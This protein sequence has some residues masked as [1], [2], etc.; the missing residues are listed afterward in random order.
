[1]E[2]GTLRIVQGHVLRLLSDGDA[3]GVACRGYGEV[4]RVGEFRGQEGVALRVDD[5][6]G[7]FHLSVCELGGLRDHRLG[8]AV[9]VHSVVIV[10]TVPRVVFLPEHAIEIAIGGIL[11][12]PG[13]YGPVVVVR[14]HD[15]L[16]LVIQIVGTA[17][18][19]RKIEH[20][21]TLRVGHDLLHLVLRVGCVE[22]D[23]VL[24][25][26]VLF[27][28]VADFLEFPHGIDVGLVVDLPFLHALDFLGM[29]RVVVEPLLLVAVERHVDVHVHG[30]VG[31][32]AVADII[33]RLHRHDGLPVE[34]VGV[35]FAIH[36]QRRSER[37][38]GTGVGLGMRG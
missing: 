37:A 13:P 12:L 24:N 35:G 31:N 33:W 27:E 14:L 23:E 22:A 38:V 21:R 18:I 8:D 6:R 3:F 15:V 16:R 34:A 7:A 17:G 19:A 9:G 36:E 30:V 5:G 32:C 11:I 29:L 25:D 10:R 26:H 1:M 28:R 2:R 4:F 20:R